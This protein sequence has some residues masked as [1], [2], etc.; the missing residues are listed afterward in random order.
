MLTS[1]RFIFW[2]AGRD[3]RSVFQ[4]QSVLSVLSHQCYF[5]EK[6]KKKSR[7]SNCVCL[8]CLPSGKLWFFKPYMPVL[9]LLWSNA[10]SVSVCELCLIPLVKQ[11]VM[12]PRISVIRAVCMSGQAYNTAPL[13]DTV[14]ALNVCHFKVKTIREDY[15]CLVCS[16]LIDLV[17]LWYQRQT[18]ILAADF[19][20]MGSDQTVNVPLKQSRSDVCFLGCSTGA[21]M[22]RIVS[23]SLH[24]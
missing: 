10:G 17:E 2:P 12:L 22:S 19:I 11:R 5:P 8:G 7:E 18:R 6:H 14:N 16:E 3:D 24:N 4:T 23:R 20:D 13:R 21:D 1:A 15:Q 9:W